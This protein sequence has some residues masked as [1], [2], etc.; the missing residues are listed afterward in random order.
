MRYTYTN[1]QDFI[2]TLFRNQWEFP[3]NDFEFSSPDA[4]REV[5]DY[6]QAHYKERPDLSVVL[7]E[8][9]SDTSVPY[10]DA[11]AALKYLVEGAN[12]GGVYA[13]YWYGYLLAFADGQRVQR[14]VQKA[15]Y[16]LERAADKQ[17][18]LANYYLGRIY[19]RREFGRLNYTLS[20]KYFKIALDNGVAQAKFNYAYSISERSCYYFNEA[21]A[22]TLYEELEEEYKDGIAANNIG[23]IYSRRN[24]DESKK[25]AFE[26]FTLGVERGENL[27]VS[28]LIYCYK[29]GAG[30]PKD[31]S[32]IYKLAKR[33]VD[34]GNEVHLN[35]LGEC[36]EYGYGVEQS[37]DK[38]LEYYDKHLSKYPQDVQCLYNLGHCY[39]SLCDGQRAAVSNSAQPVTAAQAR[40]ESLKYYRKAIDEGEKLLSDRQYIGIYGENAYI[41]SPYDFYID[42]TVKTFKYNKVGEFGRY[43]SQATRFDTPCNAKADNAQ[44]KYWDAR[45][46]FFVGVYN[47]VVLCRKQAAVN[48]YSKAANVNYT[49]ALYNL[50]R[51]CELGDGVSKDVKKA[52][53]YYEKAHYNHHAMASYRLGVLY[54]S[55]DEIERDNERAYVCMSAASRG[56]QFP[57][58]FNGWGFYTEQITPAIVDAIVYVAQRSETHLHADGTP[59]KLAIHFQPA[60][61]YRRAYATNTVAGANA[62]LSYCFRTAYLSENDQKL[63]DEAFAKYGAKCYNAETL[64]Y[65]LDNN[66]PQF[67]A[68]YDNIVCFGDLDAV[69]KTLKVLRDAK[70]T[71]LLLK[72]YERGMILG[73]AECARLYLQHNVESG[74]LVEASLAALRRMSDNGSLP[75]TVFLSE[76]NADDVELLKRCVDMGHKP[77]LR[78]LADKYFADGDFANA[79]KYYQGDDGQADAF[80]PS[81]C[82]RILGY[83]PYFYD[84]TDV[85][86][87]QAFDKIR[88]CID[89]GTKGF[90]DVNALRPAAYFPYAQSLLDYGIANNNQAALYYAMLFG[91]LDE[92]A[93]YLGVTKYASS[94]QQAERCFRLSNTAYAQ[95]NLAY[96]EYE[97]NGGLF[98]KKA[99]EAAIAKIR[100]LA[101]Q[102]FAPA[103]RFMKNKTGEEFTEAGPA[104][105]KLVLGD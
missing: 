93:V 1:V 18:P 98:K 21:E 42:T 34:G 4:M 33:C 82:C 26:Y 38:A 80:K 20:A 47:D 43:P 40:E 99:R 62:F 58:N 91:H 52:V 67:E 77:S 16:Y 31:F 48:W 23:A 87:G 25:K 104:D 46:T 100:A 84:K 81:V 73:D 74:V 66:L 68:I 69:K 3:V 102:G 60:D 11:V 12:D 7:Y 2:E 6:C 76:R 17:M 22:I 55:S 45:A 89:N 56:G 86:I 5:V 79:Y 54:S 36:Y 50:A 35:T 72:A 65:C 15:I 8:Y 10:C 24:D 75:A 14:D 59:A 13:Q 29:E 94:R 90:T 101:E 9:L 78:R 53:Y 27:A 88:D 63:R 51:C 32:K 70:R 28:N 92:A 71:D 61:E 97:A 39:M 64:K 85:E 41:S 105:N 57:L 96:S 95:Y 30:C 83:S 37:F 49:N 44:L 19:F 103:C